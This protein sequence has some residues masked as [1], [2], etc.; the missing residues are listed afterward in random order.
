VLREL[1]GTPPASIK[2]GGH[3]FAAFSNGEAEVIRTVLE[4]AGSLLFLDDVVSADEVRTLLSQ[5]CW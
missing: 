5:R 1:C 4:K 2:G 3:F